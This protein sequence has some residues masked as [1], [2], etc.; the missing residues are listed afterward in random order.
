MITMIGESVE[1]VET[2]LLMLTYFELY[3]GQRL[4]QLD[5]SMMIKH[6]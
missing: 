1:V 3:F 4:K 2:H 6:C 5:H